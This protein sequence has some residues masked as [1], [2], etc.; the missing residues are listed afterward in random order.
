MKDKMVQKCSAIASTSELPN[1]SM[2]PMGST[3][4]HGSECYDSINITFHA[5]NYS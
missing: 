4:L 2:K 3:N 5:R 1:S